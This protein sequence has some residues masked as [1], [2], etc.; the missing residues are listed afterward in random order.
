MRTIT[1]IILLGCL[2]FSCSK[3]E[4][5]VKPNDTQ[6]EIL[7]SVDHYTKSGSAINAKTDP[8]TLEEQQIKNIY[9]FLFSNTKPVQSY[10]I[11]GATFDGGSWSETEGKI[12]LDLTPEAAGERTVYIVANCDSVKEKLAKV[13]TL[14]DLNTV[15]ATLEKPWSPQLATPLL[16][17][18]S[19]VH[20]FMLNAQLDKIMLE[21]AL[22][23][24]K[25]AAFI[26][27]SK[28]VLE[29]KYEY[30]FVNFNTNTSLLRREESLDT[31]A[32][33][34]WFSATPQNDTI[35]IETYLNENNALQ[36]KNR[37]RVE[38]RLPDQPG[39]LLP[40]PE[41]GDEVYRLLLSKPV[42]RNT[43]YQYDISF[44]N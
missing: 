12:S 26:P 32:N 10:F 27:K 28:Q 34:D 43:F 4:V 35:F 11:S 33:S 1:S 20:N 36:E 41:F 22:A 8:G 15:V 9:L 23:K 19:R 13:N 2:L 6:V 25:I 14:A 39:G 3:D 16:M 44:A 38:I 21:R 42:E 24:I 40:P 37:T 31:L 30:R 18:G 7:L 17:V 5:P 29:E